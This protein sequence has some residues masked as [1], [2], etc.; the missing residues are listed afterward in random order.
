MINLGFSFIIF[1][2]PRPI[3]TVGIDQKS[4]FEVVSGGSKQFFFN[5]LNLCNESFQQNILNKSCLERSEMILI[6]L[7][8]NKVESFFSLHQPNSRMEKIFISKLMLIKIKH[9]HDIILNLLGLTYY[10]KKHRLVQ[11]YIFCRRKK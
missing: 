10:F 3:L 1:Y 7:S 9:L 6:A 5:L 8:L 2:S 4:R 11:F